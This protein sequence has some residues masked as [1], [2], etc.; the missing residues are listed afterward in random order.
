MFYHQ[1]RKSTLKRSKP[2]THLTTLTKPLVILA[3]PKRQERLKKIM[4]L[5]TFDSMLFNNI[6]LSLLT[7][8]IDYC[9]QLP[10]TANSYYSSLGGLVDHALS[11]TQAALELFHKQAISEQTPLSQEQKLWLYALL[12]A[13]IL[14]AI[15][16]LR[17][18]YKIELFN[19][20]T[21]FLKEWNPLLNSLIS[22]GHYY[23]YEFKKEGSDDDRRRI[24][25]LLAYQLMP[26]KGFAWIASQPDVLNTW[27]ALLHEDLS[28]AGVL[29]AILEYA[30]AIAIQQDIH[31]FLIENEKIGISRANRVNTTFID[32]T[33]P[34]ST[35]EQDKLLG[36]TFIAWLTR[37][38]EAGKIHLNKAPLVIIPTGLVMSYET[39]QLF[40]REHPEYKNW[41]LVQKGLMSWGLHRHYAGEPMVLKK[42]SVVLPNHLSLHH[43][44]TEKETTVSALE[45]IHKQLSGE[46]RPL[47]QLSSSGQWEAPK[48]NTTSMQQLPGFMR[49]V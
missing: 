45:L 7:N 29:G 43:Q 38:L 21:E 9:Q 48:T 34:E 33:L 26:T 24:N 11:R 32:R 2:R 41:Q 36:A 14:Q 42:Y 13:A 5:S 12:S 30:D 1:G 46:Q 27:L 17:L 35:L 31:R 47:H 15:G 6:C 22:S 23:H 39:F 37:A 16:K 28:G 49:R 19:S 3:E 10:E 4:E 8:F 40:I 18:D 20:P 25:L 44:H